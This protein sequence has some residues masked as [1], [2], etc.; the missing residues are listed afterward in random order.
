L[1]CICWSIAFTRL[2][3][4]SLLAR[5]LSM[6]YEARDSNL[7]WSDDC[8]HL[9]S[10]A[11][12]SG[13]IALMKPSWLPAVHSLSS[14]LKLIFFEVGF[15]SQAQEYPSYWFCWTHWSQHVVRHWSFTGCRWHCWLF[16]SIPKNNLENNL[17]TESWNSYW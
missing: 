11:S 9:S 8:T 7:V 6:A 17:L 5:Y 16:T 10:F 4:K 15:Y 1:L 3:L 12:S 14:V 2:L 13:H